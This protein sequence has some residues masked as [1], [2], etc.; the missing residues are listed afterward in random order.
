MNRADAQLYERALVDKARCTHL[1]MY[2]KKSW[3]DSR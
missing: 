3:H 1:D 2:R